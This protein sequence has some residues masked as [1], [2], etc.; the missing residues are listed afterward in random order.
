MDT[1]K[2]ARRR[3]T[4]A[5]TLNKIQSKSKNKRSKKEKELLKELAPFENASDEEIL[6]IP[7]DKWNDVFPNDQENAT[8]PGK[9]FCKTMRCKTKWVR[10]PY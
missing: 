3:E 1:S 5:T 2:L 6:E 9:S 4:I 8:I 10:P 7:Q